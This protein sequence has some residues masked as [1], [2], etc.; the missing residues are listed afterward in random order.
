VLPERLCVQRLGVGQNPAHQP[1]LVARLAQAA[2]NADHPLIVGQVVG[3][4]AD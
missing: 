4:G 2:A 3:D 1:N